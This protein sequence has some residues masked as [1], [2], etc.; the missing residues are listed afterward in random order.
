M[1]ILDDMDKY[2]GENV[3]DQVEETTEVDEEEEV[4]EG[5]LDVLKLKR[6][7]P[8]ER[9]QKKAQKKLAKTVNKHGKATKK[10]GSSL[11]DLQAKLLQ[12][13]LAK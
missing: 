2:I 6:S 1:S 5:L 3:E 4:D 10:A 7:T 9:E 8:K 12:Q 13:A 11:D